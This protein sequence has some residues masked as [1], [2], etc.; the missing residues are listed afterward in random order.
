MGPDHSH[1]EAVLDL[2]RDPEELWS[3]HG[4][5]SL[6][7]KDK[8]YGTGENYWRSPI[9]ININY[10]VLQRLLVS[11]IHRSH[12]SFSPPKKYHSSFQAS[13]AR[14]AARPTPAKSARDLH[15]AS[16]KLGGDSFQFLGGYRLCM[17]AV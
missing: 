15:T 11:V 10:M 12:S 6:S 5:R 4:L 16:A 7:L 9:W 3:P 1:L 13:G 8:Y 14:P 2:I 17:G